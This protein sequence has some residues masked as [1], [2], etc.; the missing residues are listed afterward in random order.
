MYVSFPQIIGWSMWFS[1]YVF[2]ERNWAK[3]E[4]TLKVL[5]DPLAKLICLTPTG[6]YNLIGF[7]HAG[8]F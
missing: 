6:L 5:L 8:K 1:D 7:T 4:S 2:L 3:D